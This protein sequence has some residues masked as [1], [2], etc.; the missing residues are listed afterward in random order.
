[1]RQI[2][3]EGRLEAVVAVP[4]RVGQYEAAFG[5]GIEHLDGLARHGCDN[6]A[7]AL[8]V[9]VDHVFD[10]A[11]YADHIGLGLARGERMHEAD[12]GGGAAHVTL[13]VL[14]AGGRFHRVA[15]GVENHALADKSERLV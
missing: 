1:R 13:H 9:A 4:E 10:Q 3:H 12:H 2:D 7:R 8:G 11:E 6:V 5:V 15:A 14:H